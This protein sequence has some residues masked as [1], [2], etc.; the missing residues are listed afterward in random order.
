MLFEQVHPYPFSTP[1][2]SSGGSLC[3][4]AEGVSEQTRLFGAPSI[5]QPLQLLR[6]QVIVVVAVV[7]LCMS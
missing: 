3:S 1:G 4:K 5:H 6:A 7:A 2:S